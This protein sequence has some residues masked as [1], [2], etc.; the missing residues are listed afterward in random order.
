MQHLVNV[1]RVLRG[2]VGECVVCVRLK[3]EQLSL[4]CAQLDHFEKHRSVVVLVRT[5]TLEQTVL[6]NLLAKFAVS[7]CF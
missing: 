3:A 6:E 1:F 4:F 5:T 2:A 7:K